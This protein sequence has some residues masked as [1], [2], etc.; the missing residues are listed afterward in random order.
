MGTRVKKDRVLH[1][2]T[3]SYPRFGRGIYSENNPP[4]TV[5][6]SPFY[7]WFKFLQL[8]EDY[9]RTAQNNGVGSCADLYK[10]FG[11]VD[12][13]DFKSWW[14]SHSYLFAD[15][16]SE[17]KLRVAKSSA[18]LA[19]FGIKEAVNVVVPLTWSQKS[20]KKHF[21]ILIT[22]L[23]V[24]MGKRGPVISNPLAKYSI[25]RRWN[26]GAMESAYDVYKA[27]QANM[28]KGPKETE[29]QQ[30]KGEVSSKFKVAWADIAIAANLKVADGMKQGKVKASDAEKRKVL[31]ILAKRHYAKA[32]AFIK[33]AAT[34]TF[35]LSQ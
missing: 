33:A 6:K 20:L 29:K 17:Y 3:K 25:G 4:S 14:K 13:I 24:E 32:E 26:C 31:T 23:G 19:D 15:E 12:G 16:D 34:S 21:A 1:F 10:D 9:R 22:K 35:P 28:E 8:N 2:S 27:R 30:H 7:W 18:D 11:D 5:K